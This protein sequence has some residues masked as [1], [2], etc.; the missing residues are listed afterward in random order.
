MLSLVWSL[1]SLVSLV[2]VVALA[3]KIYQIHREFRKL[4]MVSE[5]LSM[6]ADVMSTSETEKESEVKEE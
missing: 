5:Q 4:K 3:V 1:I 6:L 2:I